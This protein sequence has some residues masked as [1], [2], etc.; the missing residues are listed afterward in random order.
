MQFPLMSSAFWWVLKMEE[1]IW[2][3]QELWIPYN[4][5]FTAKKYLSVE[6]QLQPLSLQPE[7][8]LYTRAVL[9]PGHRVPM[10]HEVVVS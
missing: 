3:S 8:V 6:L 10:L 7:E 9:T 1:S 5:S 2:Q 4:R